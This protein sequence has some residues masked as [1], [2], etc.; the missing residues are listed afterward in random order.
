MDRE[1]NLDD[2]I[3]EDNQEYFNKPN[4]VLRVKSMTIDTFVIVTLMY[5]FSV[6]LDSLNITSGNIRG[7]ALGLI[8]LYEPLLT[9]INRTVGQKLMGLRVRQFRAYKNQKQSKNINIFLS[10]IRYIFKLLLGWISLLTIHSDTF[11]RAIH[12]K[13]GNSLMTFEK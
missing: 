13:I 10:L 1:D 9:S 8:I 3:I 5:A 7:V 2:Y 11:G 12:D 6:I 4:L